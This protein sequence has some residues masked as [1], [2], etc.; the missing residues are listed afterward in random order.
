MGDLHRYS[1]ARVVVRWS[2]ARAPSGLDIVIRLLRN[3]LVYGR[4]SRTSP[5]RFPI[6][7]RRATA[8]PR[9]PWLLVGPQAWPSRG[10]SCPRILY[11]A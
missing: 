8:L 6:L 1:S 11:I 3:S 7:I 4:L 9:R 2:R 5:G 10:A